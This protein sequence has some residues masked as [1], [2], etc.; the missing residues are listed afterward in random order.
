MKRLSV[1]DAEIMAQRFRLDVGMGMAEPVNVVTLLRG[2]R[3]IAMYRPLSENSYG[4]SIKSGSG[5]FMLVNSNLS[6][7]RQ[8]I[9]VAH[10][11]YH[12]FFDTN[13]RPHIYNGSGTGVEKEANT[14]ASALLMPKAGILQELRDEDIKSRSVAV[15]SVIRLEQLF[16]VPRASLLHRL[17]D[18]GIIDAKALKKLS[19]FGDKDSARAYGYDTSLYESGNAGLVLGDFGEKAKVLFDKGKIS[20]GRYLGLLK[21]IAT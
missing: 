21:M 1:D 13:H 7:G 11:L 5:K 15:A 9:T 19:T 17:K 8:H 16:S 18:I 3:V 10:E 14:F 12:L 2:L 6:L 4:I 20:E